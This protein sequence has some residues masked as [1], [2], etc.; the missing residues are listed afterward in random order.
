MQIK[1]PVTLGCSS[2]RR[3]QSLAIS[4]LTAR[5]PPHLQWP[6]DTLFTPPNTTSSQC[7]LR[8]SSSL[9]RLPRVSGGSPLRVP[10]PLRL[11]TSKL[12]RGPSLKPVLCPLDNAPRREGVNDEE[13][14]WYPARP[15]ADMNGTFPCMHAYA[16]GLIAAQ[17][18]IGAPCDWRDALI[19]TTSILW[20]DRQVLSHHANV[21]MGG[22]RN[23]LSIV[24]RALF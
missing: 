8:D 2:W 1:S 24:V 22:E 12:A 17:V 16:S 11:R 19:A 6:Q 7:H 10:C 21:V 15:P 5:A 3:D 23:R 14:V 4:Y 13:S 18:A 20:I 9:K